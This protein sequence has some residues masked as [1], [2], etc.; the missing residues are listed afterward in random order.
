MINDY[1]YA[2]IIECTDAGVQKGV[3][4]GKDAKFKKIGTSVFES[5]YPKYKD[6]TTGEAYH[7]YYGPSKSVAFIGEQYI[8]MAAG[9]IPIKKF[10]LYSHVPFHEKK[11]IVKLLHA[12]DKKKHLNLKLEKVNLKLKNLNTKVKKLGGSYEKNI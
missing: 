4:L 2:T 12:Y 6:I 3:N 1:Y 5:T 7:R 8:D 9:V 11:E 10:M